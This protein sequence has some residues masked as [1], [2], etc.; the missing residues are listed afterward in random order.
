MSAPDCIFCKIRDG[1][2][3]AK[4]VY[5]DDRALSFRDT[6]PQEPTHVLVI[7]RQHI[8]SLNELTDEHGAIVGH[9]FVAARKIAE[10]EGIAE[11]GY[12]TVF[13]CGKA[14]GQTV[15]HI[16]LHMLGGRS[17]SWPPG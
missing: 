5:Q 13:N 12:R 1:V 10:Q 6:N 7:P 9:L 4:I 2:I 14:A 17:L 16:H 15:W 11:A 3:P 8:G